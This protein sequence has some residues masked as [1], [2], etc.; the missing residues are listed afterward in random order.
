MK[1]P[2][3]LLLL[4]LIPS[5]LFAQD[6]QEAKMSLGVVGGAVTSAATCA[7]PSINQQQIEYD[8]SA[9]DCYGVA[10]KGQSFTPNASKEVYSII[11]YNTNASNGAGTL[12]L[13]LDDDT[14]LTADTLGSKTYSLPAN[15]AGEIEFIFDTPRPSVTAS[16]KYYFLISN[17]NATYAQRATLGARQVGDANYTGGIRCTGTSWIAAESA[18]TVYDLY[19]KVKLCE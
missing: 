4:L 17:S 8:G 5:L 15:T 1:K 13:R 6:W 2:I 11:V 19:F 10:I 9:D 3:L 16:T 14:D 18:G 12:T 7:S